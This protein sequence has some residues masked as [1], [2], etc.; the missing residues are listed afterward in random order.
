MKKLNPELEK[1]F[2]EELRIFREFYFV[3]AEEKNES[4]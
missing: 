3:L 2:P 4:K 1:Q